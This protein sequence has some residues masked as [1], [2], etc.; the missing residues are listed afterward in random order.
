MAF[1]V[2]LV[3]GAATA[4][5]AERADRT[6]AVTLESD[7]PCVINYLKQTSQCSGNV[8]VSQGTLL[9][10][11]ERLDLRETPE[12]W[13]QMQAQGSDG[14]PARVRQKRDGIDEVVEGQA[15]SIDYDSRS[16]RVTLQGGAVLRRLRSGVVVDEAQ[17]STIVWDGLI[18]ELTVQGGSATPNN[19]GGRVRAVITPRGEAA[20]AAAEPA[21]SANLQPSGALRGVK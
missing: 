5:R 7:R 12:G 16:A 21:A 6:R 8:V 17:G 1:G 2:L 13:Q 10:R 19:P 3:L 18:E 11:A 20:A 15:R 4:P 14:A 9:L